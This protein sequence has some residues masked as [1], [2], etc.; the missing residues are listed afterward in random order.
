MKE[1]KLNSVYFFSHAGITLT[2]DNP[3]IP[4][5]EENLKTFKE[6]IDKGFLKV[7]TDEHCHC[8]EA[9]SNPIL[10]EDPFSQSILVETKRYPTFTR[11]ELDKMN[12]KELLEICKENEI[13]HKSSMKVSELTDLILKNL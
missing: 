2:E 13:E 1:I 11:E 10:E 3:S 7:V 4:A 6:Y 5:T 12:K 9:I 8:T